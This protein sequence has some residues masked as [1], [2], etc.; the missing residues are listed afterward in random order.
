MENLSKFITYF[1]SISTNLL[2]VLTIF[3]GI[4]LSL[5]DINAQKY[6]IFEF[7]QQY[8]TYVGPAFFLLIAISISKVLDKI[9]I[10]IIKPR[11]DLRNLHKIFLSLTP[12]EKEFLRPYIMEKKNSIIPPVDSG[13]AGGLVAKK[14]IYRSSNVGIAFG[15]PYNLK[16]WARNYLE[17][18]PEILE[19]EKIEE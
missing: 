2:V 7:R 16:T 18:K 4:V 1:R 8:S 5:S 10:L 9:W 14:I 6:Y 13:I 19:P 17:N 12:E 15:F 3:L 11:L